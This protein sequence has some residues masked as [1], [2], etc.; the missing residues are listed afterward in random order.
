MLTGS[1]PFAGLPDSPA[2]ELLPTFRGRRYG[3]IEIVTQIM[4]VSL[5]K[6]PGFIEGL[7]QEHKPAFV[8]S[9][10]LA[11]AVPALR[12]ERA[13]INVADFGV[14]DNYGAAPRGETIDAG[15]SEMRRATWEAPRLVDMLLGHDLPAHVSWHAGTHLCNLTLYCFLGALE[16]AG[17]TKSP[18]GFLHLPYTPRQVARF[19]RDG[20]TS[21]DTA[22]LPARLEPSM[23]ITMQEHAVDLLLEN[24]LRGAEP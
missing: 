18:C 13:A 12:L 23:S 24:I 4:P 17:L 16:K 7:V 8:L 10:G 2:S 20:K 11:T 21:T 9:L 15:G 6:L 19:L 5:A 22:P 3:E 14:A 1:E